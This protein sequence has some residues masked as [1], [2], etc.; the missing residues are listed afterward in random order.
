MSEKPSLIPLF[1]ASKDRP[2]QLKLLLE[3][4]EK[5]APNLFDITVLYA[6]S[7]Y[8]YQLGYNRL[9]EETEGINWVEEQTVWRYAR[10]G[11]ETPLRVERKKGVFIEQFRDFLEKNKDDHFCLMVDDNVVYRRIP[12]T[13]EE[14]REM[15]DEDTFSFSLRLGRNTTIQNHVDGQPQ[16][17]LNVEQEHGNFIKWNWHHYH[18]SFTDYAFPFSWDGVVY[19]TSDILS[20]LDDTDLDNDPAVPESWKIF[21]LPHRLESYMGAAAEGRVSVFGQK[22]L[23]CSLNESCVVGM[24]YNKVIDVD[25]KGGAKFAANENDLCVAYLLGKCIDYD[26][27]DLSNIKS[28]HDEIPFELR[29][30]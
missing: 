9:K 17:P 12:V 16:L 20:L 24:D 30:I 14:I 4:I 5:N 3:S 2:V 23:L 10:E 18:N 29:S 1:I 26:S 13:A 21:P 15:L 8:A 27:M 19:K 28:A 22:R 6:G 25:N 7:S 11:S